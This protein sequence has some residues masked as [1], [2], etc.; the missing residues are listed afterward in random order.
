MTAELG[1]YNGNPT[2]T[3]KEDDEGKY[4]LRFTFGRAKA[5]LIVAHIADIQKFVESN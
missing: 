3:L 2:I 5:K 4:P 1:E